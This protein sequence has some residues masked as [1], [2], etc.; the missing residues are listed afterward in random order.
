MQHTAYIT[1]LPVLEQQEMFPLRNLLQSHDCILRPIVHD[2][3]VCFQDTDVVAHFFRNGQ[4]L[5]CG[6][7]VRR[8]AEIGLL[9]RHELKKVARQGR[10]V[11]ELGTGRERGGKGGD[12]H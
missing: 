1:Q 3:R 10:R 8:D 4:K 12:R 7:H 11:S 2:V 9:D 5:V 6:V